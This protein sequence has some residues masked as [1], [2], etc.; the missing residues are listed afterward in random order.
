MG[1][2]GRMVK[3]LPL[4]TVVEVCRKL[5]KEK[6]QLWERLGLGWE[7]LEAHSRSSQE[8]KN[9]SREKAG[10]NNIIN[11][12]DL[13]SNGGLAV[14]RSNTCNKTKNMSSLEENSN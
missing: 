5:K 4:T 6:L 2:D 14:W 13:V 7:N 11:I 10:L 1:N 12:S 3:E 8:Q 9:L